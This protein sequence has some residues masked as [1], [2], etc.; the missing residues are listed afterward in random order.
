MSC[1]ATRISISRSCVLRRARGAGRVHRERPGREAGSTRPARHAAAPRRDGRL[2]GERDVQLRHRGHRQAADAYLGGMAPGAPVFDSAGRFI[3]V[4]VMLVRSGAGRGDGVDVRRCPAVSAVSMRS[5]SCR[6]CC[7]RMRFAKSP[8]RRPR[9]NHGDR[10][11][12]LARRQKFR[13]MKQ[14]KTSTSTRPTTSGRRALAEPVTACCACH[15]T[16]RRARAR[17]TTRSAPAV[18]LRGLRP[19]AVRVGHQVRERHRL[20]E[21]LSRRSRARSA[22]PS[23]AA[24]S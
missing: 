5:A 1:C 22:R 10:P 18:P 15:G 7:R 8:S 13:T 14:D 23:I 20:A 17:S 4:S 2:E 11:R 3:G 16:E 24:T 9:S 19:G 21:L 12:S 6:S